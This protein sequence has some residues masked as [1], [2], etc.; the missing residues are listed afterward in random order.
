[1]DINKSFDNTND[2]I[3]VMKVYWNS[4]YGKDKSFRPLHTSELNDTDQ[5]LREF[6]IGKITGLDL[7]HSLISALFHRDHPT[8]EKHWDYDGSNC[9][10]IS[11]DENS[12]TFQCKC[13]ATWDWK[14]IYSVATSKANIKILA[15]NHEIYVQDYAYSCSG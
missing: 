7:V 14:D 13:S 3:P 6:Q 4:Y 11:N 2:L 9:D 8:L 1:V 15:S 5:K 12:V 10:Q